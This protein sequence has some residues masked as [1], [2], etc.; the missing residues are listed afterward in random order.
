MNIIFT[1]MYE[2]NAFLPIPGNNFIPEWYKKTDGYIDNK[3]TPDPN[4]GTTATIKK[5]MPVF[6]AITSGYLIVSP[7]DVYINQVFDEIDQKN[8]PNLQW[9]SESLITFH[10]NEQ[11]KLY[12]VNWGLKYPKFQNQWSIE[13]PPGY[14]CLFITPL[15][16]DLPFT[17]LPGI[18]DTD[19]YTNPVNFPFILNDAGW[20]GM[21]EAGTPIAQ[22]I[23]FKRDSWEMK[24]GSKKEKNKSFDVHRRLKSGFFNVYKNTYWSKKSFK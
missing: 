19:K 21:I 5:C 4:Y 12:P 3:K 20:E 2:N 11:A 1:N 23:P 18:V 8:V 10:D 17:I 14:S 9:A 15:H 22:V 13:T 24:I 7:A 16:R 6:D